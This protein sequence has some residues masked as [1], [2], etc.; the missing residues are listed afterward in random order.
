MKYDDA[1]W[2]YDGDFPDDLP[3]EAGATHVGMFLAWAITDDLA[4]ELHLD[5]SQ[6]SI[7]KV[8]DSVSRAKAHGSYVL[9]LIKGAL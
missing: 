5:D 3:E 7:Q 2:H 8:K 4:G 1:S 9:T 6:E